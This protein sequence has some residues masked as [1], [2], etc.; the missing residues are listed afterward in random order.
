[1]WHV[2]KF[3]SNNWL[4]VA[5]VFMLG[6]SSTP[7]PAMGSIGVVLSRDRET[8]AL[9]IRE[10]PTGLG[11]DV[12]GLLP[13]DRLKMIDG[14]LVDELD[15][16]RIQDLVRGPVGSDVMLTVIRGDEV[17]QAEV[18]RRPFGTGAPLPE[19]HEKIE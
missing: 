6:C 2:D 10:A 4:A 5:V 14:V 19:R 17:I 18:V 9:H 15:K 1:M 12:A 8:G 7:P 16:A 3:S 11:G 13:G